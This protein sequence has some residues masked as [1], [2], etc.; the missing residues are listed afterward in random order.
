MSYFFKIASLP[1]E[2]IQIHQLN[3]Q[4]FVEEIPQHTPNPERRLIDRFHDENTYLICLHEEKVVGMLAVR[5]QRP[6]SLDDKI[7]D[8][9]QYLPFV[10]EKIVEVRLLA[11]DAKHRRGRIFYGLM[12]FLM[13]YLKKQGID[14]A[15]I[16]GTTRELKLYH[17]F[18]F[19]PFAKRVGTKKAEYQPMYLTYDTYRRSD[20]F[21]IID[22]TSSYLAGPVGV[23]KHV[24]EAFAKEAKSHRNDEFI[25]QM[26]HIQKKLCSLTQVSHVQILL[27]SGTLANDAVAAQLSLEPG[28]GLILVNGEFGKRL[29]DHA[30]RFSLNFDILEEAY[31][32]PLSL[33]R[34]EELL[35]KKVY[36]WVWLVHCE[37]STGVLNDLPRMT[38]LGKKYGV[39]VVCDCI[40]SL[41]TVPC[42]LKDVFMATGVSG[43]AI[44]AL[45][46]LSFVFHKERIQPSS[47]LPRYLD[48]GMYQEWDSIPYSHSSNLMNALSVTLDQFTD[49][50]VYEETSSMYDWVR[51]QLEQRL[52]LK[53]L[54]PRDVSAPGILTIELDPRLSSSRIGERML[55]QGFHLQ[56]E[57]SYLKQRNW[58]Q[59]AF[60]GKIKRENFVRMLDSLEQVIKEGKDD[61]TQTDCS[62]K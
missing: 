61:F 24:Y 27:G 58:L 10:P 62:T 46:G 40:S 54:A 5:T 2:I 51:N 17:H 32:Q 52:G 6:F 18:G 11:V 56:F 57:S 44:G 38:R 15:V 50:K 29:V 28:C 37:T 49:S 39:Q 1:Q 9:D 42:D 45:T 53:I 3:Y 23:E 36:R 14:F 25:M 33:D 13:R 19:T 31:G 59:V 41:G 34:I 60:M 55:D 48:L 20:A 12:R 43:K 21:R 35:K 30:S 22:M 7:D 26:K 47:R 16:S 8:L 4:T